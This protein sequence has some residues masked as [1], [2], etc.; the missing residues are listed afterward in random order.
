MENKLWNVFKNTD[1]AASQNINDSLTC[2]L[3]GHHLLLFKLIEDNRTEPLQD[4]LIETA[5][6]GAMAF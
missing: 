5:H 1:N 4:L 2:N 6:R 3:R